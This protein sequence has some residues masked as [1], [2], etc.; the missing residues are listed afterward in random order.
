MKGSKGLCHYPRSLPGTREGTLKNSIQTPVPWYR[1]ILLLVGSFLSYFHPVSR[2]SPTCSSVKGILE[3]TTGGTGR[4]PNPLF[5][6]ETKIPRW[7]LRV[8]G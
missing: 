6:K 7:G 5:E 1:C 2:G 4:V 3:V 8:V